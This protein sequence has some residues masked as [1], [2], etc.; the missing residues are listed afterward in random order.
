MSSI[1]DRVKYGMIT[2]IDDNFDDM[3]DL[4]EDLGNE[5]VEEG[6]YEI[7]LQR[8]PKENGLS[9]NAEFPAAEKPFELEPLK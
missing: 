2:N 8:F 7:S 3:E 5:I 9:N 1:P 6:E 4:L